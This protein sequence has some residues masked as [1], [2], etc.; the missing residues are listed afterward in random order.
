V[1]TAPPSQVYPAPAPLPAAASPPRAA[2]QPATTPAATPAPGPAAAR[3]S[4]ATPP[5]RTQKPDVVVQ[6]TPWRKS[7]ADIP[8]PV[9]PPVVVQETAWRKSSAAIPRPVLPPEYR[10]PVTEA[11]EQVNEPP[12]PRTV[13][14]TRRTERFAG[15]WVLATA[16]V[17]GLL[18]LVLAL[19]FLPPADTPGATAWRGFQWSQLQFATG[20]S[21]HDA[22]PK[23]A[24]QVMR[25]ATTPVPVDAPVPRDEV[26]LDA[27]LADSA[28]VVPDSLAATPDSLGA[29]PGR[30]SGEK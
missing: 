26:P 24:G 17:G 27:P 18:V 10:K 25:T 9:L 6:E 12:R 8:R 29:A 7:S 4:A 11:Y 22:A 15:A 21:T 1:K 20:D 30:A 14:R 13:P 3:E 5:P 19:Q 23:T 16:T 2:T 28:G